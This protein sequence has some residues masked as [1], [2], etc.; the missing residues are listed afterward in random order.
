MKKIALLAC[1]VLIWAAGLYLTTVA[2]DIGAV[3]KAPLALGIG[4]AGTL[5]LIANN[6]FFKLD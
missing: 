2:V 1:C 3:I 5:P 4:F 6:Q